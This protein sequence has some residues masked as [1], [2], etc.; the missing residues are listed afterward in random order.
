MATM[1]PSFDRAAIDTIRGYFY[2][3]DY[4][5][6][7]VLNLVNDT[8]SILIEGIED[9]DIHTDSED[10]AIQCKYYAKTEYNHSVIAKPIRQMLDHFK[11]QKSGIATKVAY[12]LRG[13]FESGHE[14]LGRKP[15]LEELKD[16]YLTYNTF[17]KTG[18]VKTKVTHYH[19]KA[20]SLSDTDLKEFLSL[21]HIDIHAQS[22]ESQVRCLI[23][24]LQAQMGCTPFAAENFYYNNALKVIRELAIQ[25]N[26]A[27][28]S[29][30][31][32]DF[33]KK[34][35][36][37]SILFNEWFI[38]LK[39]KRSHLANIRKE[40]FTF[41][42]VSPFERVFLIEV[43]ES[44]RV[45]SD[46]KDLVFLISKKWS[47]LSKFEKKPFCPYIYLHNVSRETLVNL[48]R[49]LRSEGFNFV[50]GFDYDGADFNPNSIMLETSFHKQIKIKFFN[51]LD[52]VEHT[53]K[54]VSK[55]KELYQFYYVSPYCNLDL[56][57]VKHLKIQIEQ[58]TDIKAII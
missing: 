36:T 20:L 32:A 10:T 50:D 25:P 33:L 43:K 14:K 18:G 56:P 58:L 29:I 24:A 28:R 31:K 52:Y 13:H 37:S 39:G 21:L 42:N 3:F 2:Q 8:D 40:N 23:T 54:L 4:S 27:D 46:L 53:L 49:E 38:K 51:S 12:H 7:E 9:V 44:E 1:T 17:T 41:L 57:N 30:T 34:I 55:T 47:K 26:A 5:I 11:K 6:I 22:F 45:G 15:T 48:K 19:H 35:N 16:N